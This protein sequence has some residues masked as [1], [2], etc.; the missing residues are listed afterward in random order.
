MIVLDQDGLTLHLEDS[1]KVL[2]SLG[3]GSVDVAFYDPP[4]NVGKDYDGYS[5]NRSPE[6]YF[7]WMLEIAEQCRRICRKGILVYIGCEQR[8][9]HEEI[10]P[11]SHMIVV[12]KRAVGVMKGNYFLQYHVLLSEVKPVKKIPDLWNDIRLPGEGYFFREKRYSHP[13]LT[14]LY[15]TQ[16]ILS[17][18]TH[19]GETVLDPFCGTGTTLESAKLLNRKAIGIEQSKLYC[20]MA[21]ERVL[22]QP[23]MIK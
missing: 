10:M 17:C 14:S 1:L 7:E 23:L 5:D 21:I 4:Y 22:S 18:F 12:H 11:N 2:E 20:D 9:I 15:L 16:R 6:E 8:R 13:G 3:D 19:E